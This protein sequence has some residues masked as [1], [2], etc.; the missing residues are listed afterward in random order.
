[1]IHIPD[2]ESLP[3][4]DG[5]R[6]VPEHIAVLFKQHQIRTY[7]LTYDEAMDRLNWMNANKAVD[8]QFNKI[9]GSHLKEFGL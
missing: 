9:I 3:F 4:K 2:I 5:V 8:D 6:D 7:E 1:M